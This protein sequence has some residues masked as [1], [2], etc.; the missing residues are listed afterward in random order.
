MIAIERPTPAQRTRRLAV[1][2]AAVF[3]VIV[4]V[5]QALGGFGLSQAEFAADGNQ[6]LR[7]AGYAFSSWSLLYL[8]ILI[9]AGRQALPQP[10]ESVLT[11][12]MGWP[13]VVAV[14]GI[15]FWIVMA[16]L[17]LK[18]ARGLAIVAPLRA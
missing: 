16:A 8:G 15:G 10:G 17:H 3:A 5:V 13:S 7:A 9:Y 4:P 14:F 2:A 11:N 12:R 18:A 1:L 6:T